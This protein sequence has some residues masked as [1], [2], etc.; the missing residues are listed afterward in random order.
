MSNKTDLIAAEPLIAKVETID[1]P[2]AATK[3]NKDRQLSGVGPLKTLAGIALIA[4][5]GWVFF[6][7]GA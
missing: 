2:A 3:A 5:V 6:G 4:F 7:R 1:L